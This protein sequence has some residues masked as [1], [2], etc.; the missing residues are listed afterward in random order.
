M[1]RKHGCSPR[2]LYDVIN[3]FRRPESAQVANDVRAILNEK[4]QFKKIEFPVLADLDQ[5]K[6]VC[7][8][9]WSEQLAHQLQALPRF[10]AYWGEL[11]TFFAWLEDTANIL[12]NQL[13]AI[14]SMSAD[15]ATANSLIVGS[16]GF[17]ALDRVRF[18]AVNRLCVELDY[19]KEYGQR[20]SYLIEPYALRTTVEGNTLLYGVKLPTA[21]VR[22]FRTDRIIGVSLTNQSFTPRF[23][24][25][26]IPEGPVYLNARR[27]TSTSIPSPYV[28]QST[29]RTRVSRTNRSRGGPSYI[30]KCPVC[31]KQFTRTTQIPTLNA[32]NNKRGMP[33]YGRAGIFVR[34]KYK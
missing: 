33:C 4:C 12:V 19:R 29:R 11:P 22:C 15:E 1:R 18:A 3:F 25:D 10:E 30:Y 34:T 23:S 32:H 27:R 20:L 16:L 6:E 17:G 21:E 7:A 13:P 2:D 9:G 28:S 31:K 24:I 14:P 26:F 5:H 8:S